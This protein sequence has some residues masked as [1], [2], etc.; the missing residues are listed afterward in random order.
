M[1]IRSTPATHHVAIAE[2]HGQRRVVPG[3]LVAGAGDAVLFH[4]VGG[5]AVR[6]FFPTPFLADPDTGK[7]LER[8]TLEAGGTAVATVPAGDALRP[9]SH[10][11]MAYCEE[12]DDLAVGG[13]QPKI[14]IYR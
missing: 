14:I 6:L 11:Y 13:S 10:T 3:H 4:A 12:A 9:G 8:L 5:G 2:D 7:P 1:E